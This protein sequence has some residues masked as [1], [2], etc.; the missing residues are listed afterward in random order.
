[1]ARQAR[2]K[3]DSI[4]LVDPLIETY[5]A[6]V[7]GCPY[8]RGKLGGKP[9]AMVAT[10]LEEL[11][12]PQKADTL[13]MVSVLQV[14][15]PTKQPP[16]VAPVPAPCHPATLQPSSQASPRRHNDRRVARG[17]GVSLCVLRACVRHLRRVWC[18]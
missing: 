12:L 15:R 8:A 6:R 13:V 14:R 1:M 9:V 4:T 3:V 16:S 7:K 5:A 11:S 18:V 2:P 10:P 17:T